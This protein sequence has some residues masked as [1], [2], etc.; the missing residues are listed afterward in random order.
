M[1]HVEFRS[2]GSRQ[3]CRRGTTTRAALAAFICLFCVASLVATLSC[4]S[5]RQTQAAT[6]LL[7]PVFSDYKL[8]GSV[9][10]VRDPSMIRQA[11]TYYAFSTD[12]GAPVDGS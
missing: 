4:G 9:E 2:V 7:S 12:D 10:P 3:F 8:T 6:M 1:C 5:V 11:S